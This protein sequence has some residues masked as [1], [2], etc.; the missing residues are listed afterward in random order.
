MLQ[1]I[2]RA[3]GAAV[4]EGRVKAMAGKAIVEGFKRQ[5]GA[6]TYLTL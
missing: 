1:S 3:A 2:Q 6:Y 5:M 4:I